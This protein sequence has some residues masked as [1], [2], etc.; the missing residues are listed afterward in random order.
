MNCVKTAKT[1][2]VILSGANRDIATRS[3]PVGQVHYCNCLG[4]KSSCLRV[5]YVDIDR[6]L[7]IVPLY[8]RYN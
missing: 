5:A 6:K 4:C 8:V 7:L 2:T 1:E 3:E